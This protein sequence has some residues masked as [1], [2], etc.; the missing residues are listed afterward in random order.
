M[1]A[2]KTTEYKML[3]M[4]V[5]DQAKVDSLKAMA[6]SI[7]QLPAVVRVRVNWN[8]H[9]LEILHQYPTTELMKVSI[10]HCLLLA[11]SN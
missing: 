9:A 6:T 11:G 3:N 8:D 4:L 10:V 2:T 7:R 1:K 5:G